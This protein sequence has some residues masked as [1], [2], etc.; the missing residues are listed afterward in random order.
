M[1]GV[2]TQTK[3]LE[4]ELKQLLPSARIYTVPHPPNIAVER[5]PLPPRPP[6]RVLFLGFVRAYKGVDVLLKALEYLP[7]RSVRVT[8][9]SEFWDPTAAEVG[10]I[11]AG[12]RDP[13][14]VSVRDGYVPD[15][16]MGA[17]LAT[18]HV[19]VLP[20]REATQSGLVP[21][22]HAA[23]RPVVASAVGGLAEQV[24][25]G[26]DGVLVE[27]GDPRALAHALLKAERRL[28]AL[29]EGIDPDTSWDEFAT[30]ILVAGGVAAS[31]Q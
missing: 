12:L 10:E 9:S 19:V 5:Q 11:V 18:H 30:T 6:F 29:C 2:V 3:A 14:S 31:G 1:T 25:D 22:A 8:I 16:A 7:R 15:E 13:Q 27:P 4:R 24:R 17:L 26:V 28:D 23:G 20:Y 21:L